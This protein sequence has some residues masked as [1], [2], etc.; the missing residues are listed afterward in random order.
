MCYDSKARPPITPIAGGAESTTELTL[1]AADGTNFRA[2]AARAAKPTGAGI[3][4]L[5]DIR[6]LHTF[7]EELAVRFAENGIDAVAI[8]YFGRTAGLGARPDDFEWQPHVAATKAATLNQDIAAA[9]TYIRSPEGGAV[10]SLF[11]VGFCFGG[12][13]SWQQAAAGLHLAGAIGFYG[14]PVGPT[15]DGSPAPVENA[16]KYTCPILGL[17][18]GEDH[19][20]PQT[21][22]DAFNQALDAAQVPHEIVVYPGAPH[23]F[24]DRHQ[25]TY[26]EASADAWRR[27][28]AFINANSK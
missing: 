26:A 3:L 9:A 19:G 18:G 16:S 8:D 11:T 22:V 28:L 17:F 20:I 2:Y 12:A 21:A 23:S 27:I 4:V 24:F 13:L 10:R 14:R 15:R 25:P 5:P 1:T 6:G 7:Y